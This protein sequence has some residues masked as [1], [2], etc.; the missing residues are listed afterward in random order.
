MDIKIETL[1]DQWELAYGRWQMQIILSDEMERLNHM[2]SDLIAALLKARDILYTRMMEMKQALN[3]DVNGSSDGQA[4]TKKNRIR[5][6][7][8]EIRRSTNYLID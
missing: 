5:N 7:R 8:Q 4:Q 2:F 6:P 3:Q 1:E